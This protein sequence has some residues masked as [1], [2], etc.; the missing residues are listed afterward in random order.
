M[1]SEL[2]H[3]RRHRHVGEHELRIRRGQQADHNHGPGVTP[4]GS[5]GSRQPLATYVYG[6]DRREPR[7]DPGERRWHLHLHVRQC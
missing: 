1:T 7:D 2:R 5:G 6:Y 3:D 4:T